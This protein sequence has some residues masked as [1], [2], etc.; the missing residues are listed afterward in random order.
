[1]LFVAWKGLKIHTT[2]NSLEGNENLL[3]ET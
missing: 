2:M 3:Y 1:M